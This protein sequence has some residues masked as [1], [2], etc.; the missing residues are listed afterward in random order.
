MT[1]AERD[2]LRASLPDERRKLADERCL[3]GED[4]MAIYDL[5]LVFRAGVRSVVMDA[6]KRKRRSCPNVV[7]HRNVQDG[8]EESHEQC[9]RCGRPR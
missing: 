7:F 6:R 2:I 4:W 5:H 9:D 1:P 3:T 8:I